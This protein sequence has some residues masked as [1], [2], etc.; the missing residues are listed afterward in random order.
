MVWVVFAVVGVAVLIA[1]SS[2]WWAHRQVR[3]GAILLGLCVVSIFGIAKQAAWGVD[4]VR[5]DSG[6]WCLTYQHPDGDTLSECRPTEEEAW[7][8]A[9]A[10]DAQ[11]A[12]EYG[13][14]EK[15][16]ATGVAFTAAFYIS[17]AGGVSA[18]M[19]ALVIGR[20]SNSSPGSTGED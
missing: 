9:G 17:L 12:P 15:T 8:W 18:L 19:W 16:T 4:E 11:L 3:S 2:L 1:L 10:L 14:R 7:A 5:V 6:E 20:R 13:P